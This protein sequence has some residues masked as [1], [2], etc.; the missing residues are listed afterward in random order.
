MKKLKTKLFISLWLVATA[1]TACFVAAYTINIGN[2]ESY[3]T[4][5]LNK[6]ILRNSEWWTWIVVDGNWYEI[7]I[8]SGRAEWLWKLSVYWICN[9][10]GWNCKKVSDLSTWTHITIN[11]TQNDYICTRSSNNSLDCTT[12]K[13]WTNFN[14]NN[15]KTRYCTYTPNSGL[16]CNTDITIP[17]VNNNTIT[18]ALANTNSSGSFTLNQNTDKLI[19]LTG[20]WA[21]IW[22]TGSTNKYCIYSGGNIINCNQPWGVTIWLTGSTNKYCVYSGGNTINC[23]QAWGGGDSLWTWGNYGIKPNSSTDIDLRNSSNIYRWSSLKIGWVYNSAYEPPIDT[24][25]VV[26]FHTNWVKFGDARNAS[27]WI[28]IQWQVLIWSN[29][30]NQNYINIYS[31]WTPSSSNKHYEIMANKE[32][33]IWTYSW[34]YIYFKNYS[35][36]DGSEYRIWVNTTN[37]QAT[38]DVN[39]SVR[40]STDWTNC[41][42]PCNPDSKWSI[43]YRGNAFYWCDGTS[44]KKFAM[45]STTTTTYL[46]CESMTGTMPGSSNY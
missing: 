21:T 45:G 42:P 13:L 39:W 33:E 30:S 25:Y 19:T 44:R 34:A 18:I 7:A 11:W 29:G 28:A 22:S 6:L 37:P 46:S 38:F 32:L 5:N 16:N 14:T 2:Q 1:V 4:L 17:T 15:A 31:S 41:F 9:Q 36:N 20:N 3:G 10:N 40:I 12:A 23:D 43:M 35:N 27:E 24:W 26:N 8:A